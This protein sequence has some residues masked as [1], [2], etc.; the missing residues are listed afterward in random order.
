MGIFRRRRYEPSRI[1][2]SLDPYHYPVD[3]FGNAV[4]TPSPR[5]SVDDRSTQPR[6]GVEPVREE[7]DADSDEPGRTPD[8]VIDLAAIEAEEAAEPA[9]SSPFDTAI[10]NH[11]AAIAARRAAEGEGVGDPGEGTAHS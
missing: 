8:E 3:E 10:A 6:S 4:P 1:A 11:Y 2:S 5:T 9:G 7:L